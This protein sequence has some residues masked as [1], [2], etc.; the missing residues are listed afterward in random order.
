MSIAEEIA[1]QPAAWRRAAQLAPQ[2]AGLLPAQGEAVCVVGCGTSLHIAETWGAKR[3]A[4][5]HGPTEFF[6]AADLSPSRPYDLLV[7]IARSGTM[8]DVVQALKQSPA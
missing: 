6:P 4:S 7:A 5:A 3:V 8:S 1:S 2:V